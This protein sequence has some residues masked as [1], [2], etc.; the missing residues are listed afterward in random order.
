MRGMK[1]TSGEKFD[2]KAPE[3]GNYQFCF[4]NPSSTPETVSF[5]IH[6]GHIPN[7]SDLAKHGHFHF[8]YS[9]TIV[10]L[11]IIPLINTVSR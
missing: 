10:N 6:V 5:Y 7:E 4:R 3:S 2:F 1:G 11:F 9:F 8:H